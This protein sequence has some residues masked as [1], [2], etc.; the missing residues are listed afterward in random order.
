VRIYKDG[1][2]NGRP[3]FTMKFVRGGTLADRLPGLSGDPRAAVRL[4]L[5]VIDAVEYLHRRGQVHRDLKPTNILLDEAGEPCLS[6]FG[7]VKDLAEPAGPDDLVPASP[8]AA[9]STAPDG[10]TLT[11]PPGSDRPNTR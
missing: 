8:L 3:Y 10:E 9:G 4:L 6:D 5:K 1:D 2:A 11:A 7:L